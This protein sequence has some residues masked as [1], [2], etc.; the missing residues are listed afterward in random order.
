[1]MVSIFKDAYDYANWIYKSRRPIEIVSVI[2]FN[3]ELV[4][5]YKLK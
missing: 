3:D 5:T 4:V 1:M 2:V